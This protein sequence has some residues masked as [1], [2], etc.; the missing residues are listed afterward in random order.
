MEN[1][2]LPSLLVKVF[3]SILMAVIVYLFVLSGNL[4]SVSAWIYSVFLMFIFYTLIQGTKVS[5]FRRIYVI[6]FSLLF[7]IS[8][9]AHLRE[10]FNGMTLNEAA[11]LTNAIP[12]NQFL[13]P[14]LPLFL[15]FVRT[16]QFPSPMAGGILSVFGL[17][18]VWLMA[19]ITVGKGWC[20][21]V[22]P[23]GGYEDFFSRVLKKPVFSVSH[24]TKHI[25]RFQIF[26]FALVLLASAIF[27]MPVYV[28]WLNPFN[29]ITGH[30]TTGGIHGTV[31]FF[32]STFLFIFLVVIIPVL[33][34]KRFQCSAYCPL[35][36][37][38]NFTN[39]VSFFKVV[40]DETA[41]NQCMK[42]VESCQFCAIDAGTFGEEMSQTSQMVLTPTISMAC[43]LCGECIDVCPQ[44]AMRFEYSFVKS[45]A[46][47]PKMLD[48]FTA[49][50]L[51]V[52]GV[53]TF[54]VF[55]SSHFAVD[56]L[57][58]IASFLRSVV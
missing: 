27:L 4:S 17:V 25:R 20:G 41:C 56:A 23:F 2:K 24:F 32:I 33:T 10:A 53:F 52:F 14:V 50:H 21:W 48:F 1:K 40:I 58:L 46:V 42:C 19:S 8:Y 47:V 13:I 34:R 12:F 43:A 16:I 29:I 18:L 5:F 37:L 6:V 55:I 11:V 15:A 26:F 3:Y 51:F 31:V 38:Q 28:Y 7:T 9:I 36:A 54:C 57:N 30:F 49:S 45:S 35:G 44:N 39:K 22:C